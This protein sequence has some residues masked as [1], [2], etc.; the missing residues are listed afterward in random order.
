[1][2]SLPMQTSAQDLITEQRVYSGSGYIITCTL[3]NTWQEGYTVD[4]TIENTGKETIENWSVETSLFHSVSNIWNAY[5]A[6]PDEDHFVI[7][8]A[9]WNQ[10][11]LVGKTVSFGFHSEDRFRGF[12]DSMEVTGGRTVITD[13]EDYTIQYRQLN[14]WGEGYSGVIEITNRTNRVL[15]DWT[16]SFTFDRMITQMSNGVIQLHNGN[17]YT[18]GNA[19]Y[20]ENIKARQT[21]SI[22]VIGTGGMNGMKPSGY[23]LTEKRYGKKTGEESGAGDGKE[24]ETGSG[25]G[26]GKENGTGGGKDDGSGNVAGDGKDDGSGNETGDGRGDGPENETGDG[27]DDGLEDGTGHT[28]TFC[29][30]EPDAE[31]IPAPCTVGDGELVPYPD[32]PEREGYLCLGWY[33]D[34][35]LTEY[36]DF[37]SHTITED[38]NLYPQWYDYDC[39]TDCDGDGLDD[40]LEELLGTD[41]QKADTDGDGVSDDIEID[42]L[43]T[44]PTLYDTDENQIG[45]GEE[46]F[47]GDSLNNLQELERGCSPVSEDSDQ[48]GLR[49]GEEVC[50]YRTDPLKQDTDGDGASDCR[51][52]EI[53]SDPLAAET[54]FAAKIFSDDVAN[55]IR[56]SVS[57]VLRGKQVDTLQ[58]DPTR[59][60]ALFP[61]NMPG[62]LGKAYDF[63]V[64][65][66][67]DRA[68]LSFTFPEEYLEDDFFDP[69]IYY[70][71]EKEQKLEEMDTTVQGNTATAV[72]GHFSTY[73]LLDRTERENAKQWV[74]PLDDEIFQ[75]IEVVLVVDDSDSMEW[76]DPKSKRL[77]V[78]RKLVKCLPLGSKVGLVKFDNN[79]SVL[80]GKLTEDREKVL[81]YLQD[82]YFQHRGGTYMYE[83]I[84]DGLSLFESQD[85][86]T[87]RMMIVLSDGEAH[88]VHRHEEIVDR[89]MDED[90]EIHT[91]GL[92]DSIKYFNKYLKP[93][94]EDTMGGFYLSEN[95]AQLRMIY[96]FISQD[97]DKR[98][99]GDGD[100]ITDYMEDHATL[101]NGVGIPL[102]QN[103][104]DTDGDGLSDGEEVT[105]I[106]VEQR[107]ADNL[108]S[109]TLQTASSPT[110]ADSD[111]DGL[112]D[113][114]PRF[115]N[116]HIVAPKDPEPNKTNGKGKVWAHHVAEYQSKVTPTKYGVEQK[117][118]SKNVVK[119][120]KGKLTAKLKKMIADRAVNLALKARKKAVEAMQDPSKQ[121]KAMQLIKKARKYIQRY[122]KE[123]SAT[124]AALGAYVAN[125]VQDEQK[126]A[127]HSQPDTWQ[128]DFG[129]NDFY[130]EVFRLATL[131][132]NDDAEALTMTGQYKL[133]FWK[134][135]Y[136]GL[137]SGGE[138]G[139]Y[140]YTR[141]SSGVGHFDA[142][143][144][145]VPMSVNLYSHRG[146]TDTVFRWNPEQEQWWVTGFSGANKKFID[147]KRE[148]MELIGCVDLSKFPDLYKA[149][150]NYK[151]EET[152]E[153]LFDDDH[154]LIWLD[155][156]EGVEEGGE[157]Q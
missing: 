97:I 117:P 119:H 14:D 35:E 102:D 9:G 94:A 128:R 64:D 83:G 100:G 135:D 136:W 115:A 116:G 101:F 10:D 156:Y 154:H 112:N 82:T 84:D 21:V 145:E 67:F 150:K 1:M 126:M 133:W 109:Y 90:V 80:T 114:T 87:L 12:P 7:G 2:N 32:D 57:V 13:Q 111:G 20:N 17:Q 134:G 96:D 99:D 3:A 107:E 51:E 91:I 92:G 157:L 118:E 88:D 138:M 79:S 93:L 40:A 5:I 130:D 38:V 76:N 60:E 23:L 143:N 65:G 31:N 151:K 47:D 78:A 105:G 39:E 71:N 70:F 11:I 52:V 137:H 22:G 46:D 77:K 25:S 37:D 113:Y 139:L 43:D 127:Y 81:N 55:G 153:L 53:G 27:K 4:V 41:P 36:F 61:Q 26:D 89:A 24:N 86:K 42:V 73:V 125:V 141:T 124:A 131:M 103:S 44:D 19:S 50:R 146:E 18:V 155:F 33:L 15:E 142:I 140:K 45:D 120:L 66:I 62:Y 95:A 129:Y 48:D 6:N 29:V 63:S 148:E 58:V 28:V 74:E 72:T 34:R 152:F 121:E 85:E 59:S 104:A 16:L 49:D 149:F 68:E 98:A 122:C 75:N 132:H 123:K 106:Q 144:F 56:A 108:V 8:N 110:S 30:V 54:E 147:L 69:T